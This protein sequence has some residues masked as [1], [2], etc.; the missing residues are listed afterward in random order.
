VL[1]AAV[2]FAATIIEGIIGILLFG[3][4]TGFIFVVVSKLYKIRLKGYKKT[5]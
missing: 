3:W 1:L 2:A 4:S 5:D